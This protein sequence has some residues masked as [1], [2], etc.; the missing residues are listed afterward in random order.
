MKKLTAKEAMSSV[1]GS[2]PRSGRNATRS[3][4]SASSD[5]DGERAQHGDRQRP[6]GEQQQRIADRG[7]E[8]AMGEVDEAHDAEDEAD[9]ERGQRVEPADGDGVDD[10]LGEVDHRGTAA[11]AMSTPK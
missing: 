9:A 4:T 8:L 2:A 3:M 7:D 11:P 5:G 6:A 10:V 1:S